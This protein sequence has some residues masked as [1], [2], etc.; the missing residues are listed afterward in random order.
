MNDT[1]LTEHERQQALLRSLWRR[2]PDEVL[3]PWLRAG[4]R[5]ARGLAA[6]RANAGA[7]AER[8]LASTYPTVQALLG[9]ESF[10]GLARACWHACP[11]AHGDMARFGEAL[12][13]FIAAEPRLA[14]LPYLADVARLEALIAQAESAADVQPAPQTFERL[15]SEDPERLRFALAPGF[16]LLRSPHPVVAI[17]RAHQPGENADAWFETA[18]EAMQAGEGEV[19]LVW[20]QGWKAQVQAVGEASARWCELLCAGASLGEALSRAPQ[21]FGFEPWLLQ[22]LPQGWVLAVERL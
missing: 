13:A 19:A 4:P 10:A 2:Q 14:D 16:A 11:P 8:A 17:W 22:A 21:A 9:E 7:N 3:A 15:A 18:R 6:Y 5:Q 1:A 12:P 20:R